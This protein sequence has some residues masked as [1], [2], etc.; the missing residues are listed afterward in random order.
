[1]TSSRKS[2]CLILLTQQRLRYNEWL[3]LEY[4]AQQPLSSF[5]CSRADGKPPRS[6]HIYDEQRSIRG[7]VMTEFITTVG[8]ASV[9]SFIRTKRAAELIKDENLNSLKTK[10]DIG[11]DVFMQAEM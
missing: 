7:P 9:I 4:N 3:N 8:Q 5:I 11:C 10:I 2:I 6:E 1:M